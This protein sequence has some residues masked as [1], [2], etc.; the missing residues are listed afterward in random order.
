M[1]FASPLI[2]GFNRADENPLSQSGQWLALAGGAVQF[3]VLG[4]K[5]AC[6]GGA[7]SLK[8]AYRSTTD[9]D[10]QECWLTMPTK[11]GS[12]DFVAVALRVSAGGGSSFNL[13][14]WR[15]MTQSGVD[16]WEIVRVS[17]GAG[18]VVKTGNFELLDGDQLLA[19]IVGSLVTGQVWRNEVLMLNVEYVDSAVLGSGAL[20]IGASNTV[21]RFDDF[22][23][24]AANP[25][26]SGSYLNA[27]V[28]VVR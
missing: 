25:T 22:G 15:F 24:G 27:K 11:P 13:Y 4:M 5:C 20:G 12:G 14:E 7:G 17:L 1:A 26:V 21:V 19:N 16:L 10:N 8:I 28:G 23:G 2:D 9:T 3:Q 6:I 18:T